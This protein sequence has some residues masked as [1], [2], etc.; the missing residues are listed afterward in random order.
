MM[1]KG[2]LAASDP[3]ARMLTILPQKSKR[4]QYMK[5]TWFTGVSSYLGLVEA[6]V[7]VKLGL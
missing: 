7:E 1:K 5:K 4:G 6:L 2:E 3:Y